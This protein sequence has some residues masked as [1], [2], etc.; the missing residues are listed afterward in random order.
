LENRSKEKPEWVD[1]LPNIPLKELK[2]WYI[3]ETLERCEGNRT[4]TAK[5]LNISLRGLRLYLK[6]LRTAGYRIPSSNAS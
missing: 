6:R 5:C 4:H 1:S 3:I 2:D